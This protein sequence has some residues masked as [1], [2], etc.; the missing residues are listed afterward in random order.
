MMKLLWAP[1]P[2][3]PAPVR[4]L[5]EEVDSLRHARQMDLLGLS[6]HMRRDIG[7]DGSDGR[8]TRPAVPHLPTV[9]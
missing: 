3:R 4:G 7:L 1:R 8:T 2:A 6:R 9:I 5:G